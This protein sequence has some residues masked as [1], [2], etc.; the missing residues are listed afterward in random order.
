MTN[1]L[2][3]Q[4]PDPCLM[5]IESSVIFPQKII[6]AGD[7][8]LVLCSSESSTTSLPAPTVTTS[9]LS[10][11]STLSTP[12]SSNVN[13]K[14]SVNLKPPSSSKLEKNSSTSSGSIIYSCVANRDII[15]AEYGSKQ[16][17]FTQV[18]K[19]ILE[20]IPNEDNKLSYSFE[21][22]YFH[23]IVSEGITYLCIAD[24]NFGRRIPFAYLDDI[25]ERFKSQYRERAKAT[26]PMAMQ[27]DFSR[28]LLKQMEF[29]SNNTNAD[30][31][32]QLRKDLSDVKDIMVSNIDK[33]IDRGQKIDILVDKTENL[34]AESVTFKKKAVE[35]KRVMW[36]KNAKLM[37]LVVVVVI[38][39]IYVI[40]AIACGG[41]ALPNC[42][43][44]ET[45]PPPASPIPSPSVPGF[46]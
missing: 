10:Q 34:T 4:F 14:K 30:R 32:L 20:Q 1:F 26:I 22:L 44:H 19:R 38:I 40:I 41:P 17:T 31:I 45:P 42:I 13:L 28:V 39:I 3:E 25:R 11:S 15:L 16:G 9:T 7:Y 29:Y 36:W 43:K 2:I 8:V 24:E 46:F 12:L 37:V 33:I 21:K 27:S 6:V 23:Y 5:G 35:L 18:V